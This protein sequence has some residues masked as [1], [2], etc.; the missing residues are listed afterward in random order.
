M[1][2]IVQRRPCLLFSSL[3][4]L[5]SVYQPLRLNAVIMGLDESSYIKSIL[6]DTST[7]KVFFNIQSHNRC[8][9]A[10]VDGSPHEGL[11]LHIVYKLLACSYLARPPCFCHLV[12][13]FCFS[14]W[15]SSQLLYSRGRKQSCQMLFLPNRKANVVPASHYYRN[16]TVCQ[17]WTEPCVLLSFIHPHCR[18]CR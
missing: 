2:V 17:M 1:S 7:H 13:T 4:L 12:V 8:R 3:F 9:A 10:L 15:C 18:Y 5:H 14:P 11:L 16:I 6:T